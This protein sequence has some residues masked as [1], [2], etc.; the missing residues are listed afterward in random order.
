MNE[1]KK[2]PDVEKANSLIESAE[3]EIKF[4]LSLDIRDES[5]NTIIKNVYESFR[6]LGEALLVKKGIMYT[7]HI[8]SINE[9]LKININTPRPTYLLENLRKLRHKINYNGYRANIDEAKE[10]VSITK[11]CFP[12]L[13]SEVKKLIK[14]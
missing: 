4:S 14:R 10:A 8:Q 13:L 12:S 11:S 5:A 2:S 9:L 1:R 7:D 3:K 6:M